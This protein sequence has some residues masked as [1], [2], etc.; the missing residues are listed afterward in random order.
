MAAQPPIKLDFLTKL[1]SINFPSSNGPILR[2]NYTSSTPQGGA[3]NE[4]TLKI[5]GYATV[6]WP[7]TPGFFMLVKGQTVVELTQPPTK[8]MLKNLVMW[9][10]PTTGGFPNDLL[11]NIPKLKS[12]LQASKYPLD[13]TFETP[14]LAGFPGTTVNSWGVGFTNISGLAA[15]GSGYP[16]FPF[17]PGRTANDA[18]VAIYGPNAGLTDPRIAGVSDAAGAFA[19]DYSSVGG[20]GLLP[21]QYKLPDLSD[22]QGAANALAAAINAG[23]GKKDGF[24]FEGATYDIF[25]QS[26]NANSAYTALITTHTAAEQAGFRLTCT[27]TTETLDKASNMFTEKDI[28]TD[29]AFDISDTDGST[30]APETL[31]I[32]TTDKTV[33]VTGGQHSSG[34]GGSGGSGGSGP[35]GG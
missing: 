32:S 35:T 18:F 21:F 20:P 24:T 19:A 13:M 10:G 17:P 26:T 3:I 30:I 1:L 23:I 14:S 4:G 5:S 11:I 9:A 25:G 31:G 22:A 12:A 7:I 33:V 6:Q 28:D 8:A 27:V 15:Y 34:G 29:G 16:R 2:I